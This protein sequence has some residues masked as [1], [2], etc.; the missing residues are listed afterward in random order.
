MA[1]AFVFVLDSFGIGGAADADK[2]GDAGADT[3]GHIAEACATGKGDRDGLRQGPLMLPNMLSLGLGEAARIATGLAFGNGAA[4]LPS[5]F[6]G[7]AQEISAGKDTPSGHWEIAGLP[8]RFDWGYFPD[9][10]PAFPAALTEAMIRE[11]QVPGI[12]ANRH[13]PGTT[14]IED[15]G[16]EHIRTGKPI[17]YTSIDSVLQIAAHE[18]HF[19]L[20]RLYDFC[21]VVRRLCDPLHVGRVIARPFL[22]ESRDTFKRTPNRKDYAVPPPQPTLLDRVLDHGGRVIAIGKIGDIF[23]HRGVSD[24]RKG[25][26]N[27]AMFDA[28]LGALDD[29]KDGDFVFANFV[30][31]DTE[32][33]HRRDVP[34]YAA[35]LEAFDRRVPEALAKLKAGDLFLLTADHGNDPTWRG[36]DHTRE[37]IPIAGLAPGLAGG[38][39]GLRPTFSDIGATVA[40]H[41]GI[42]PGQHGASFLA[43]L[44]G[45][46]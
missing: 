39:V 23:A 36:T 28:A 41:L 8:A 11:G 3:L 9:T 7:A 6:H 14:V 4:L 45:H 15:F 29:A 35:A 42:A 26:G 19:G 16:E 20:Q 38:G 1:R 21:K 17:C 22:G 32:F 5:S 13:A 34:G 18:E 10:V 46:A 24:V 40:E 43:Q 27:M 37:R 30:D 2:Y 33:G 25:A 31:F 12:L 44:G